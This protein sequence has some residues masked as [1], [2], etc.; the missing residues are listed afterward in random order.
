MVPSAVLIGSSMKLSMSSAAWWTDATW[1]ASIWARAAMPIV[2]NI[3]DLDKRR[4]HGR[5]V[6]H[7]MDVLAVVRLHHV[8]LEVDPTMSLSREV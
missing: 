4:R 5:H 8:R 6:Q 3:V 7:A 2:P 1:V